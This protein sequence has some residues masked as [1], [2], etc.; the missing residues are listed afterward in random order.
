MT[1]SSPAVFPVP[2][3][4]GSADVSP[5]AAPR[6]DDSRLR[7]DDLCPDEPAGCCQR[8][9]EKPKT[10]PV[11][12]DEP[13]G[14]G[15]ADPDAPIADDT[16]VNAQHEE[17]RVGE[18]DGMAAPDEGSEFV[19]TIS[20]ADL[21]NP[22][23]LLAAIAEA[24]AAQMG[25]SAPRDLRLVL[26]PA[27]GTQAADAATKTISVPLNAESLSLSGKGQGPGRGRAIAATISTI[28]QAALAYAKE[29]GIGKNPVASSS[30]NTSP[31]ATTPA[32]GVASP[33]MPVGVTEGEK[34]SVSAATTS[35]SKTELGRENFLPFHNQQYTIGR[36][37]AGTDGALQD[38]SMRSASRQIHHR[39]AAPP[40]EM[41][42]GGAMMAENSSD[43]GK[44]WTNG[45]GE[46]AFTNARLSHLFERVAGTMP[47]Q[48]ATAV[49]PP[50]A[51]ASV[52]SPPPVVPA[53]PVAE[54][55]L[56]G[57]LSNAV[58]R[59]ILRGQD[60][61]SLTIRFEQGGS[62][63]L[64][65][66][67]QNGEIKTQ[68]R[69]DVAGLENALRAAWTTFSQDWND[70]GVKLAT[71]VFSTSPETTPDQ[72]HSTAHQEE[73]AESEGGTGRARFHGHHR[74]GGAVRHPRT[75]P[76]AAGTP[77]QPSQSHQR[78]LYVWA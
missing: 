40:A 23:K 42:G 32:K 56:L 2:A 11:S 60:Q 65:L 62:L 58:E 1:S 61:L 52:A 64:R 10:E 39:V 26:Q 17:E 24:L 73:R 47:N 29:L 12:T 72:H 51:S 76:P 37:R 14:V 70:R 44:G 16:V 28:V 18:V 49:P 74:L 35:E 33:A 25:D 7:F 63:A 9:A 48:A 68:I 75:K 46:Q 22:A 67:L 78:G 54:A 8:R 30:A 57:P 19:I 66:A 50:A 3:G 31:V 69:T 77:D 43:A 5:S 21:H 45:S 55:A 27:S 71:P 34:T 13:T 59:M 20:R 4:A 41:R 38:E 6:H 36:T 15:A 53:I